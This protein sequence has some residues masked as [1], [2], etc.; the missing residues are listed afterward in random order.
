M[1]VVAVSSLLSLV[2]SRMPWCV[3][4]VLIGRFS[5]GGLYRG[6]WLFAILAVFRILV[7]LCSLAFSMLPFT[8]ALQV[9][10]EGV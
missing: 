10:W 5:T 3:H 2:C 8:C 4:L 6:C 1:F 7:S 9:W